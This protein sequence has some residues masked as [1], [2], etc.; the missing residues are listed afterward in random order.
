MD[1]FSQAMLSSID[2]GDINNKL[3]V[4]SK[5]AL[6]YPRLEAAGALL[7]DLLDFYRWIHIELAYRMT[8][9]YAEKHTIQEVISKEDQE[10]KKITTEKE[11]VGFEPVQLYERVKGTN[12]MLYFM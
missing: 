5:F 7:P 1:E 10:Y 11:Y 12:S 4:L 6:E 2:I 9:K 8:H 3:Y